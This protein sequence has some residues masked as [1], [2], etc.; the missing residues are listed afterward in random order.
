[1]NSPV[2]VNGLWPQLRHALGLQGFP[3]LL[4]RLGYVTEEARVR[5]TPRRA[6]NEV[7]VSDPTQ[8]APET[9]K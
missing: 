2:E 4:F 7:L 3:Q 8:A 9:Q 1:L 5:V 6:V